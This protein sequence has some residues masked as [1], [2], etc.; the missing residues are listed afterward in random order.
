MASLERQGRFTVARADDR[1]AF[2]LEVQPQQV[3]DVALVVDDEDRLH[4]AEG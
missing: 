1:E 4:P 2:L 3:D